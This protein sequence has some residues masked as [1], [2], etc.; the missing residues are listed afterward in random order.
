M[1]KILVTGATGQIGKAVVEALV[2]R[3][4]QVRAAARNAVTLW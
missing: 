4:I 3:R 2:D 1:E